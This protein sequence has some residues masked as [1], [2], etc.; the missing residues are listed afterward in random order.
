[1]SRHWK[2]FLSVLTLALPLPV[3]ASSFSIES[4]GTSLGL[5]NA[6]L[7]STT[8][9]VLNWVLGLMT[10][11][12]VAMIIFSGFIA[13]TASE[14][15]RGERARRVITGAVIGLIIILLAWAVVLFVARSTANVTTGA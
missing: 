5:G 12:A 3:L 11:I 4:V 6:D 13:A 14:A 8:L 1:M 7:R 15:E 9:N 2:K 10:L